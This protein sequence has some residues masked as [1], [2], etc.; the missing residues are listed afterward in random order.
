ML[1]VNFYYFLN[2]FTVFYNLKKMRF[3]GL[4]IKEKY[5]Y[6]RLK[7]PPFKIIKKKEGWYS[8]SIIYN[9]FA[10]LLRSSFQI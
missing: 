8:R 10:K 1:S 7:R 9:Q 6:F 4:K 5:Q 2:L 3:S